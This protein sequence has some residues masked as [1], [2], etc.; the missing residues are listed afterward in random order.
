MTILLWHNKEDAVHAVKKTAYRL[1]RE[2]PEYSYSG[3]LKNHS[4]QTATQMVDKNCT[5][6]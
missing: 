1:L 5:V 6:Q 3:S 2:V 4:E